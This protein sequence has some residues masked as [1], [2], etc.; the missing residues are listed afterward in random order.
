MLVAFICTCSNAETLARGVFKKAGVRDYMSVP[1]YRGKEKLRALMNSLPEGARR[2][3][4]AQTLVDFVRERGSFVLI[5]GY[6]E[7]NLVWA[8]AKRSSAKEQLDAEIIA[9]RYQ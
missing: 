1:V 6:T 3:L 2:S 5:I 4:G 9:S 8:N 7:D